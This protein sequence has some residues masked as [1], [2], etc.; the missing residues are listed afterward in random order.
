M[1]DA[2]EI[3][4][5]VDG[6]GIAA[7]FGEAAQDRPPQ[8]DAELGRREAT[9]SQQE[10]DGAAR[11]QRQQ[12]AEADEQR[13]RQS[14]ELPT[15]H[16][17]HRMYPLGGRAS[18][19]ESHGVRVAC[20]PE[21][22]LRRNAAWAIAG[23][24][25]YAAGQCAVLIVLAKLGS[26]ELVGRFALALAITAPVMLATGLQLRVLQATD[27]RGEHPFSTYLGLRIV[28]TLVALAAIWVAALAGGYSR[29]MRALILLVGLAKAFEA[30][31]DVVFGRLQQQEDLR[32]VALSMLAKGVL[33]VASIALGLWLGL[34]LVAATALLAASWGA[35]LVV[36]DLPAARRLGSLRPA[37]SP[38]ALGA[39]AWLALPM[40]LGAG[41]QSLMTNVPR[42]AIEAH[43]GPAALGWFAAIAYLVSAGNQPVMALWAAAG[44]R[45]AKRFVADRA[46]YR[47]LTARTL[48]VA[49]GMAALTAGAAAALGGPLL[50]LLYTAEYAAHADVLVWLAVVA[51]VGY[52]ASALATSITAARRFP[53]QLGVT[54]LTVAVSWLASTLLVPAFGLRG[55][56]WALLAATLVQ[57][58]CLAVVYRR[59]ARTEVAS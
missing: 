20:S 40:G 17:P 30:V 12:R 57:T 5:V 34:G 7:L 36:Y 8:R 43:A 27:A 38:R 28:T 55:A 50:A 32:R 18:V 49:G 33:S 41:L 54:A 6:D 31:S 29:S 26:A 25:G 21:P 37:F 52:A 44:P 3:H 13:L 53:A 58:A 9:E 35:W 46:G 45:L 15:P 11:Q 24:V 51:G 39:L 56:A 14:K 10:L 59:H 22:S 48:L 47:R 4:A 16:R 1:V 23:N 42:Y 2:E 19:D